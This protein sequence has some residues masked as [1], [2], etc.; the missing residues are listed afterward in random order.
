[1]KTWISFL[2][3]YILS[4]SFGG[5]LLV[6]LWC[7]LNKLINKFISTNGT[8]RIFKA[9]ILFYFIPIV[10]WERFYDMISDEELLSSVPIIGLI[11]P[12]MSQILFIPF[13]VWIIGAIIVSLYT[14]YSYA[15][16]HIHVMRYNALITNPAMINM[17][18]QI[19]QKLKLKKLLPLYYNDN[20]SSP[21]LVGIF[22]PKILLPSSFPTKDLKVM[23][24]H[25]MTHYK[26]HDLVFKQLGNLILCLHW[27]NPFVYKL[28]KLINEW[29]E[30]NCDKLCCLN[31][32][33]FSPKDY[34]SSLLKLAT[35]PPMSFQLN[36][37]AFSEKTSQL[38]PRIRRIA[39]LQKP[40]K[41]AHSVA[42]II[43][44]GFF[45]FGSITVNAAGNEVLTYYYDWYYNTSTYIQEEPVSLPDTPVS[46]QSGDAYIET[47]DRYANASTDNISNEMISYFWRIKKNNGINSMK[48]DAKKGQVLYVT[49]YVIQQEPKLHHGVIDLNGNIHYVDGSSFVVFRYEIP[50]DGEYTIFS[51]NPN[52]EDVNING[53][54]YFE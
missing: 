42:L 32:G 11:N 5:T 17:E 35:L 33:F 9:I 13:I 50:E 41:Y 14:F 18:K 34:A 7:T 26:Q 48:I 15:Y 53:M 47:G 20:I 2:E 3:F 22:F 30:F 21:M 52:D 27:F 12:H 25:E 46:A 16:F 10:Y 38:E 37:S 44:I 43:C 23:L 40:I 1:M 8:Y 29:C 28:T 39:T 36:Y 19:S 6:C 51:Q 24:Y 31:H 45:V 4:T 54:Y 49:H